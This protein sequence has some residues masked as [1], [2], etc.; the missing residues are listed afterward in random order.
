MNRLTILLSGAL[1]AMTMYGAEPDNFFKILTSPEVTDTD[2]TFR[3]YA[4]HATSV[5]VRL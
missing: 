3:I 5:A 4:P 1:A 2:V